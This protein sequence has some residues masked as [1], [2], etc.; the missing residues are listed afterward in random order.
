MA[1][2]LYSEPWLCGSSVGFGRY[3]SAVRSDTDDLSGAASRVSSPYGSLRPSSSWASPRF[4]H[5]HARPGGVPRD[6]T[7]SW[8][9]RQAGLTPSPPGEGFWF[10]GVSVPKLYEP[11]WTAPPPASGGCAGWVRCHTQTGAGVPL[12]LACRCSLARA[13][14]PAPEAEWRRRQRTRLVEGFVERLVDPLTPSL[15]RP[16]GPLKVPWMPVRPI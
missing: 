3:F 7:S 2:P 9:R 14:A 8:F 11:G 5:S 12:G 6:R 4:Q 15:N 10:W 1:E 16:I 13:P